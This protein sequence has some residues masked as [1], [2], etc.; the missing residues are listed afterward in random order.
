MNGS[1]KLCF[2]ISCILVLIMLSA[3]EAEQQIPLQE[4]SGTESES[5][6]DSMGESD[7]E[8]VEEPATEEL[9]EQIYVFVCGC[10]VNPGVYLLD[11]GSRVCDGI[12]LAGGLTEDADC[13]AVNQAREI[14]DGEK[15]YIPAVGENYTETE[16]VSELEMNHTNSS[17]LI[18]LNRATREELLTLPGVGE[19]KADAILNYR[20]KNGGFHSKEELM[21]ITGIKEGVFHKLENMI[22]VDSM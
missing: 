20:E 15:I 13:N 8:P 19:S 6:S 12:E 1:W 10:V 9:N 21:N 3:C 17:G 2:V 7:T 22:C 18:D 4:Y 5:E 16:P 14:V 11:P